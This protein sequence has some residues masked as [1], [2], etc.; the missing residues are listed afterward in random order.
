MFADGRLTAPYDLIGAWAAD[1]VHALVARG[2]RISLLTAEG[3]AIHAGGGSSVEELAYMVSG[4]VEHMRMLE[5][6]GVRLEDAVR[7]VTF[8]MAADADLFTTIAKFRAFRLLWGRVAEAADL[9]PG[10]ARLAGE[11]A[12]R[13]MTRRDPWVNILRVAVAVAGAGLGGA[14]TVIAQPFTAARGLPDGFARRLARNTQLVLLE[15]SGLARVA[16]PAAGAGYVE[17][18]TRNLAE[19]AW[20][21]FRDIERQGGLIASLRKGDFQARVL[22]TAQKRRANVATRRE[23]ILGVSEFAWLSEASVRTIDVE[24]FNLRRSGTSLDLPEPGRGERFE[25]MVARAAEGASLADMLASLKTEWERTEH[26]PKMRDAEP[27]ERLRDASDRRRDDTG[28]GP[29]VFLAS[30]GDPARHVTRAGWAAN[31]FAAGG[32]QVLRGEGGRD[33]AVIAAAFARSDATVACI[34]GTD[35]DY[36]ARASV[37]AGALKAMGAEGVYLAGRP[38][39]G[40]ASL[41]RA[42]VD[43][44]LFNG[45]DILAV[46]DDAH[47]RLGL[48]VAADDA[49]GDAA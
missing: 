29:R 26:V 38:G 16:D 1:I 21:L 6:R 7:Q 8:V 40:E 13:M 34:C 43:G 37:T 9:P 17:E 19:G 47:R 24:P 39:D 2:G 14:D 12:W 31:A 48:A 36:A 32:I 4:G 22:R 27:F 11:T 42:G 23:P 35:E 5:Q 3:R 30:L 10:P 33:P 20:E 46:L 44:F 49:S 18:I 28:E 25:R 15:E 45:C 41:R